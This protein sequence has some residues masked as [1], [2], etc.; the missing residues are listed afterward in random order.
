[1]T[2]GTTGVLSGR[3][4]PSRSRSGQAG[5]SLRRLLPGQH[6]PAGP[7][8]SRPGRPA[9][10]RGGLCRPRGR[11]GDRPKLREALGRCRALGATLL[12]AKLDRLARDV[13]F[14]AGLMKEGVPFVAC[15]MPNAT[16]VMLHIHAAMSEEEARAI[17][18]RT[19][20][21]LVAAKTRGTKLG[22]PRLRA[23][24]PE[25]ARTAA[26]EAWRVG[27]SW[28]LDELAR[29]CSSTQCARGAVSSW[30]ALGGDVGL[31]DVATHA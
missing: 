29:Y 27:I 9:L 17:S 16:P 11:R 21:A 4:D 22:N 31:G 19:K 8:R 3:A 25:L 15:D 1:M 5:P 23:G 20:A 6:R 7:Q 26:A 14:I 30:W 28:R 10:R 2:E 13:H 24:S 12:I 18:A